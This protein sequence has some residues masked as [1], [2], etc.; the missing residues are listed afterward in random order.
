MGKGEVCSPNSEAD[1]A[2]IVALKRG[3]NRR[4]R[5][6][7]AEDGVPVV[8]S[9]IRI[10]RELKVEQGERC[11]VA[12]CRRGLLSWRSLLLAKANGEPYLRRIVQKEDAEQALCVHAPPF[13]IS[14]DNGRLLNSELAATSTKRRAGD[15]E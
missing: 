3:G 12:A 11:G 7:G 14:I 8:P 9:C 6:H 1:A 5:C 15:K 4:W 10:S 13:T 2:C